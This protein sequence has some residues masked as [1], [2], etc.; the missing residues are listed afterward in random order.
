MG[1]AVCFLVQSEIFGK[2][3]RLLES[4]RNVL[5][6][7]IWFQYTM[8]VVIIVW[9]YLGRNERS[10][11]RRIGLDL[12]NLALSEGK[13]ESGCFTIADNLDAIQPTLNMSVSLNDPALVRTIHL[14][15]YFSSM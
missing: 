10:A 15:W 9:L 3:G 6:H 13:T 5:D 7:F 11:V 4:I 2:L 12:I 1:I 8:N 14:P